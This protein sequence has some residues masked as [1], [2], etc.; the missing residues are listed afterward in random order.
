MSMFK[1][2]GVIAGGVVIGATTTMVLKDKY[3]FVSK[4]EDKLADKM[5]EKTGEAIKG[6]GEKVIESA[7]DDDKV[8]DSNKK[9]EDKKPN[10]LDG[11]KVENPSKKLDELVDKIEQVEKLVGEIKD[12]LKSSNNEPEELTK[13][14]IKVINDTVNET[15]KEA[16]EAAISRD[17]RK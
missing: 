8:S 1:T 3:N 14:T 6:I 9:V 5:K 16:V 7:S 4:V 15:V 10:N 2:I 17:E 11:K 12:I 13:A